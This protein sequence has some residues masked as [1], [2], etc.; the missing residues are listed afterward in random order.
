MRYIVW[1]QVAHISVAQWG[2]INWT[3]IIISGLVFSLKTNYH[4]NICIS[5]LLQVIINNDKYFKSYNY[6]F[7]V[8]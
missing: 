1:F 6:T 8:K 7:A 3:I 5:R 4:Y 2:Y